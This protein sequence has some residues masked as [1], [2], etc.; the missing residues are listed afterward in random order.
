MLWQQFQ[1]D[2]INEFFRGEVKADE[3]RFQ[4]A[5]GI[6]KKKDLVKALTPFTLNFGTSPAGSVPTVVYIALENPGLL[7]M[8][9]RFLTPRDFGLDE[10]PK[11]AD[12]HGLGPDDEAHYAWVEDHEIFAVEPREAEIPPGGFV[13]VRLSYRHVN[14]GTHILPLTLDILE[15]RSCLFYLKAHTLN[16]NAARLSVRQ[17]TLNMRPVPI[18]ERNGLRQVMELANAG[19]V[20]AEWRVVM[21]PVEALTAANYGF[22]ILQVYP[23]KGTLQPRTQTYIHFTFTPLEAKKY[24]C[25]MQVQMLRGSDDAVVEE[26]QFE[27]VCQGYDPREGMPFPPV[28]F[29]ET[30]PL[31]C[32]APVP[33]FAAALSIEDLHF[34]AVPL[35]A[36][37]SRIVVLVNY[38][39]EYTLNYVW[40]QKEMFLPT[41]FGHELTITPE[42]GQLG[43]GSHVLVSFE[44]ASE[45][46][47]AITGEVCC[48]LE[49]TH[50][51]SFA[52]FAGANRAPQMEPEEILAEHS[53]HVH[54]PAYSLKDPYQMQHVSVVHRLTVSRFRHLMRTPAGQKFLNDNLHR[55]ALLSSHLPA[56][57]PE[58]QLT[59]TLGNSAVPRK[60]V[61]HAPVPSNMPLHLRL[62]AVVADWEVP[63]DTNPV[64][65]ERWFPHLKI[66]EDVPT[67]RIPDSRWAN[68]G[69][70]TPADEVQKA[71]MTEAVAIGTLA[72]ILKD[73]VAMPE[74]RHRLDLIHSQETP[75]EFAFGVTPPPSPRGP[76]TA[77][78]AQYG[79]TDG[80]KGLKEEAV[81]EPPPPSL[82]EIIRTA[83]EEERFEHYQTRLEQEKQK[84]VKKRLTRFEMGS[85]AEGD[86][87][88]SDTKGSIYVPHSPSGTDEELSTDKFFK[89]T[90]GAVMLEHQDQ[91]NFRLAAGVVLRE[92]LKTTIGD[93]IDGRS[94]GADSTWVD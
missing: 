21:D 60:E 73:V 71:E 41:S 26:L 93:T 69:P 59:A 81:P 43:P 35:R 32:Y 30:L 75:V 34:G 54:K 88:P 47:I 44:I 28:I 25:P 7:P 4:H 79:P 33:D 23:Q 10:I 72:S 18:G 49:W 67:G 39:T 48:V 89:P 92:A 61:G 8:R 91:P 65:E 80:T 58:H 70:G 64:P 45:T 90:D 12:E 16:P 24:S 37:E 63:E 84:E 51:S 86:S 27:L 66:P 82:P 55:T 76:S 15:G 19:N 83:S 3:R 29:P 62:T 14:V 87:D 13:H 53:D 9:F 31:Q 1:V 22:E 20:P 68:D 78:I 42:S 46:P 2:A 6:D 52:A 85:K 40:D 17:A 36:R 74:M 77:N 56:V 57:Q 11:W 50:M 94:L 5:M 38:S